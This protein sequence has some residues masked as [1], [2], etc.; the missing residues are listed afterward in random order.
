MYAHLT[1]KPSDGQCIIC[2]AL[3]SKVEDFGV[4][5]MAMMVVMKKAGRANTQRECAM[6]V[7]KTGVGEK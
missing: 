1:H 5:L 4:F 7:S 2:T 6:D 3:I